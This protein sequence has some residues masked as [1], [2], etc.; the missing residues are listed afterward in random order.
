MDQATTSELNELKSLQALLQTNQPSTTLKGKHV[1]IPVTSKAYFEGT[2]EPSCKISSTTTA[3]RKEEHNDCIVN[4]NSIAVEEK[5]LVNVGKECMVEMNRVEACEFVEKKISKIR[6]LNNDVDSNIKTK[7]SGN[8]KL[9][10]KKGFLNREKKSSKQKATSKSSKR[11]RMNS[12]HTVESGNGFSALNES[13]P[14]SAPILPFMEIREEIDRD[15]NEVKAEALNVSNELVNFQR[16]LKEKKAVMNKED[17]DKSKQ[18][19]N[20]DRNEIVDALLENLPEQND[21]N[22]NEGGVE[23]AAYNESTNNNIKN[24]IQKRTKGYDEITSR[25]DRLIL[26]EEEDAKKKAENAKSSKRLIGKGW[27]KGFFEK[28]PSASTKPKVRNKAEARVSD[29]NIES[30]I[31]EKHPNKKTV[32]FKASN[33]VKEIPRIGNRSIAE[34]VIPTG[35][36]LHLSP[37]PIP[38]R[39][40][41][42][43]GNIFERN[44]SQSNNILQQPQT[45]AEPRKKLSKFA[46]RRQQQRL[47]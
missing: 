3:T 28:S 20:Q 12:S 15:G 46:Q 2:L 1:R 26:L 22:H 47:Q 10:I 40:T 38:K 4:K 36:K 11:E 34:A 43:I 21:I 25:L 16:E 9:K 18:D 41:V 19:I 42:S 8:T 44:Q 45:T 37:Q 33:E 35:S 14:P 6:K 24:K 13:P 30:S 27:A 39:E 5:I 29:K 32:R 17:N 23:S 31:E 7:K